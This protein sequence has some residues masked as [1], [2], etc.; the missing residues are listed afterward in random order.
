MLGSVRSDNLY[1]FPEC[2]KLKCVFFWSDLMKCLPQTFYSA[3]KLNAVGG[4]NAFERGFCLMEPDRTNLEYFKTKLPIG[5]FSNA[6]VM[7]GKQRLYRFLSSTQNAAPST[8][9]SAGGNPSRVYSPI[10]L[11]NIAGLQRESL[12]TPCR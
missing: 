8:L 1:S 4:R 6:P 5:I 2:L 3:P 11:Q 7:C 12:R 9:F 10:V